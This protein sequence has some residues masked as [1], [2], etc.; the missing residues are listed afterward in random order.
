MQQLFWCFSFCGGGQS[1]GNQSAESTLAPFP[2]PTS[3]MIGPLHLPVQDR[4]INCTCQH[5]TKSLSLAM[6]T[7]WMCMH[8]HLDNA[9]RWALVCIPSFARPAAR[10][11]LLSFWGPLWSVAGTRASVTSDDR[12]E[13]ETQMLV[14][15][16]VPGERE[17]QPC[18]LSPEDRRTY[19][20]HNSRRS[21]ASRTLERNAHAAHRTP[22]THQAQTRDLKNRDPKRRTQQVN[23]CRGGD[24][25]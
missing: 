11:M 9:R 15:R 19:G 20:P 7:R 16:V 6:H 13:I 1:T 14:E 23:T 10:G 21:T 5:F 18:G 4:S 3:Y 12:L 24:S 22:H 25:Q 2:E 8:V 17:D